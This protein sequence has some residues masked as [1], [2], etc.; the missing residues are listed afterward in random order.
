MACG[1]LGRV[2]RSVQ[3]PLPAQSRHTQRAPQCPLH[4]C[5]REKAALSSGC[6]PHPATALSRELNLAPCYLEVLV[7][8]QAA[9]AARHVRKASSRR[10]R[11]VRREVRWRWTLNVLWTAA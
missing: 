6:E 10:T 11:S 9:V 4:V 3:R 8:T 5:A 7:R 1:S 2:S